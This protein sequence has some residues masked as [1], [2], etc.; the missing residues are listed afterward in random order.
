LQNN[1][2]LFSDKF[3]FTLFDAQSSNVLYSKLFNL[4][5]YSP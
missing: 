4:S 1:L 3:E 2:N 5:Q